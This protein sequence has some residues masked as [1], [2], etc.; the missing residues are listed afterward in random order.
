MTLVA[1]EEG[2]AGDIW[3]VEGKDHEMVIDRMT[4]YTVTLNSVSQPQESGWGFDLGKWNDVI[5]RIRED[6]T[7]VAGGD[8]VHLYVPATELYLVK[9]YIDPQWPLLSGWFGFQTGRRPEP[10]TDD[11]G[12]FFH[13]SADE[14]LAVERLFRP[15][16]IL[17]PSMSII[18]AEGRAWTFEAPLHFVDQSSE[19]GI[20]L[21]PLT[22]PDDPDRTVELNLTS[23]AE[24]MSEWT[25]HSG[26][27]ASVFDQDPASED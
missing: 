4:K 27:D 22:I 20:P 6:L 16:A 18:D 1:P 7:D 10:D 23:Y 3:R 25:R 8:V 21:W 17:E 14:N 9:V 5:Y 24:Q 13:P 2:R 26:V 12:L 15:F 19:R 11:E